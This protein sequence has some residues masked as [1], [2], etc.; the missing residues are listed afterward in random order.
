MTDK[1]KQIREALEIGRVYVDSISQALVNFGFNSNKI[2]IKPNLDKIDTALTALSELEAQ[3]MQPSDDVVENIRK[4]IYILTSA[5]HYEG[6]KVRVFT[7]AGINMFMDRIKAAIAAMPI[8]NNAQLIAE[9]DEDI[10]FER[11]ELKECREDKMLNSYAAGYSA[12][13]IEACQKIKT[14]LSPQCNTP[15]PC[16]HRFIG[17]SEGNSPTCV[18]CGLKQSDYATQDNKMVGENER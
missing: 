16:I 15:E 6:H 1:L 2:I 11:G 9:I 14:A 5:S 17:V 18:E 4:D 10:E 7:E 8:P 13:Y 12:G 3:Q